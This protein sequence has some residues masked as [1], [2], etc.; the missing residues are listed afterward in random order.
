M[1]NSG[2]CTNSA[3]ELDIQIGRTPQPAASGRLGEVANVR[4]LELHL[5]E[6]GFA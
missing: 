3:E 5:A 1:P 6:I 2:H 4:F